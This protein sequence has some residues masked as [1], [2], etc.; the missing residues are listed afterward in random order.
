MHTHTHTHTHTLAGRDTHITK[1]LAD[2]QVGPPALGV[3]V[4]LTYVR[5]HTCVHLSIC[6]DSVKYPCAVGL[7]DASIQAG[8][9]L[10]GRGWFCNA[11]T[12]WDCISKSYFHSSFLLTH[13]S[14][15]RL[16]KFSN[17]STF[18]HSMHTNCNN[19]ICNLRTN[20]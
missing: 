2:I 11:R 12:A 5:T 17:S 13:I 7:W 19:S 10:S 3:G 20:I 1:V 4:H 16:R 18:I 14:R 6:T 15:M 8:H 9:L